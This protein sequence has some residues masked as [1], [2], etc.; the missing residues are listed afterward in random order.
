VLARL[1][2]AGCAGADAN[3][4]G[5]VSAADLPRMIKVPSQAK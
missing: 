5:A 2:A 1:L 3:D 4:D